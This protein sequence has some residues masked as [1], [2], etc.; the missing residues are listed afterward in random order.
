MARPNQ[1]GNIRLYALLARDAHRAVV[2][3]RG[4]SKQVLLLSWDT[5]KDLIEDGQWLKGRIYERRCDLSPDGRL[6]LYFAATY[7][8]PL[9]SW[10]AISRPP[11]L[12]AL[13]LWP[14]GDGW[15]GGGEFKTND[16]VLLNHCANEMQLAPD[17]RCRNGCTCAHSASTL[18]GAKTSRC[19]GNGWRG[20]DGLLS[21]KPGLS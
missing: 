7:R 5:A 11:F 14:K 12:S 13:A 2:F 1:A 3:R 6:L 16:T 17:F 20:T 21:T 10:S 9:F 4:P 18:D 19:G 15:G 8:K